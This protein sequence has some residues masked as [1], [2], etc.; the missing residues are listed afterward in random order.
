MEKQLITLSIDEIF[1]PFEYTQQYYVVETLCYNQA[2]MQ[3]GTYMRP[4][5][6]N[7]LTL[8]KFPD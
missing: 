5:N 1:L 2:N 4:A 6:L 7:N 3:P 8:L